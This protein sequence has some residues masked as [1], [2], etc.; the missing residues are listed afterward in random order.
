MV[1]VKATCLSYARDHRWLVAAV[2][3]AIAFVSALVGAA[4]GYDAAKADVIAEGVHVGRVD[5]GGLAPLAAQAKVNRGYRSLARPLVLRAGRHRFVLTPTEAGLVLDSHAAVSDALDRSRRG[6]FLPRAV[7][8][9]TGGDVDARVP[10]PVTYDEAAVDR[11]VRMV[12]KTLEQPPLSARVHPTAERLVVARGRDGITLVARRLRRQVGHALVAPTAPRVIAVVRRHVRPHVTVAELIRKYP[13]YITVDRG[14]FQLR[15]Y[16]NLK[17][18]RAYPIAVGQIGL[19]TPAGIYH[20]QSKVVDPAWAVPNS[21]WAGSLAGSVIPP[22][23]G[24]P[25][26]ARWLGIF[27]G[28]GIH[29]TADTGSLGSAASHGCIRMAVPDV[30]DLYDRVEVGTPVYIG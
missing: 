11:F 9:L 4:Y 29:G 1:A 17:F 16:E 10:P 30:I 5:V 20:I 24:N 26:Q 14:N 3:A 2:S 6:W 18:A 28:A 13:S 25:L 15:V 7:R 23:P 22:G 27:N 21:A 8:E 12:E 19:E